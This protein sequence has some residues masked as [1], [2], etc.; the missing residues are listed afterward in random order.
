M[1]KCLNCGTALSCGCQK[2]VASDG[3]AVCTNCLSKYENHLSIIKNGVPANAP[4][5]VGVK[6]NP[7]KQ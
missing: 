2:R 6:Y 7:P 4:V 5:N 1:S 3:K